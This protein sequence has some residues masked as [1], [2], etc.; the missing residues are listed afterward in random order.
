MHGISVF[1]GNIR[2]DKLRTSKTPECFNK[3][4]VAENCIRK[5]Y[6]FF[7]KVIRKT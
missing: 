1:R 5:V 7:A 6:L 2:T 3:K 4:K